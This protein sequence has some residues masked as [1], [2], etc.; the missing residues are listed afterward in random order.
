MADG[1]SG[2]RVMKEEKNTVP[3]CNIMG[4]NIAAID[5]N[6]LLTYLDRNIT[7]L[8]GDYICVSNV[9]TTV[10]AYENDEYR[11]IQNGGILAIPDGG[12]L[13]SV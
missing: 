9:H 8:S 1:K 12:P 6:W 5:M 10:M 2:V 13:S 3:V 7:S 4:V 11:A